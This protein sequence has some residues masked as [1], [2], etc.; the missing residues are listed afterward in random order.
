M[1]TN[2]RQANTKAYV[3]GIVSDKKLEIKTENGQNRIEGSVTIKTSE[4]NFVQFHVYCNQMTKDK[5]ESKTYPGLLTVM[6]EY[7]SIADYGEEEADRVRVSGVFNLFR[8]K[9]SETRLS[10]N[11]N[12]FNRINDDS[13][14]PKAEFEVEGFIKAI[15]PEVDTEGQE[16][17]RIKVILWVPTYNGI[18]PLELIADKENANEID[19]IY[20]IGQTTVFYGNIINNRIVT[21]TEKPVAFGKPKVET[22][23]SFVNELV[24]TG[25]EAPYEDEVGDRVPYNKDVI[26]AAVQER[27]NQIQEERNKA[28]NATPQKEA[29]PSGARHGRKLGF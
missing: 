28:N 8:G 17:D 13:F 19:N 9:N 3:E 5:K 10:Y 22:R 4:K 1:E 11:A 12:F 26:Q 27:E 16:T 15:V 18:E 21:T 25:G 29:R 14:E 24:I 7:K 20:D 2:L 23:T 6:N